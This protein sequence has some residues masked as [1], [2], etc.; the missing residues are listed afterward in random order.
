MWSWYDAG[1]FPMMN[2]FTVGQS[3]TAAVWTFGML[4]AT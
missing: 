4:A 1:G 3:L 2:E